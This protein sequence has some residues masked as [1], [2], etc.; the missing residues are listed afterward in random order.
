[1]DEDTLFISFICQK[2]LHDFPLYPEPILRWSEKI[3]KEALSL[4]EFQLRE[5][6]YVIGKHKCAGN[7]QYLRKERWIHHS[8][9]LWDYKNKHMDLLLHPKKT[10]RYREGRTH[11]DFLTPLRQ[12]LPS[13]D[14]FIEGLKAALAKRYPVQEVSLG[15]VSHFLEEPHRK[16]TVLL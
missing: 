16:S 6:D 8:T 4:P 9:F 13:K 14:L 3:Y 2:D 1:V 12:H 15:E 7:A 10:P 11:E 5:N